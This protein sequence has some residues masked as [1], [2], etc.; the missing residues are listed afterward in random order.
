MRRAPARR[1]ARGG[2]RMVLAQALAIL[3]LAGCGGGGDTQ[4]KV[5]AASSLK[6][7]LPSYEPGA[8]YSFAGSDELAAQIRAGARPDVFA[9]ANTTLPDDLHARGLL[10]RPVVF[11]TNRLVIAVPAGSAKVRSIEDLS[12]PGVTV[13]A[14]SRSVPVGAYTRAVL[15]RLGEREAEEVEANVRSNEPDVAGVVGKVTQGAVDAGLVYVTDVKAA[16]GRLKA[17]PIPARLQPT[18]RYAA[19]VVRGTKHAGDA[20]AFVDGLV[21]GKGTEALRAAGFGAP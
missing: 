18:V 5:S 10:E 17:I 15:A 14:G 11:A 20:R 12:R 21:R 9:A 6:V 16:G 3:A 7:A 19:A 1:S 13:A 4:L 2:A 8:S